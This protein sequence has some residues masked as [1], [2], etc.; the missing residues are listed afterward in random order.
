MED[1]HILSLIH[2]GNYYASTS[3]LSGYQMI[4][5]RYHVYNRYSS[6]NSKFKADWS[7]RYT[8]LERSSRSYGLMFSNYHRYAKEIIMYQHDVILLPNDLF[9]HLCCHNSCLNS[10]IKVDF[11]CQS[12]QSHTSAMN[13]FF[14]FVFNQL[15]P[16]DHMF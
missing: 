15:H 14:P 6:P 5:P 16:R 9:D 13:S 4:V 12:F 2:D 1:L 8:I 10:K 11:C 7:Q 3:M